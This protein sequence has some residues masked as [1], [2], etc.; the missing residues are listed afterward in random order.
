MALLFVLSFATISL[1]Q[2]PVIDY[3]QTPFAPNISDVLVQLQLA[4]GYRADRYIPRFDCSGSLHGIRCDNGT[5]YAV[6]RSL[7]LESAVQRPIATIPSEIGLLTTLKDLTIERVTYTTLPP[8]ILRLTQLTRLALLD[9]DFLAPIPHYLI[10]QPSVT[11]C[12]LRP[13]YNAIGRQ[14]TTCDV[15]SF[16][17]IVGLDP[18]CDRFCDEASLY[19]TDIVT[20]HNRDS[21]LG[22]HTGPKYPPV[23]TFFLAPGVTTAPV[24]TT[25]T[26]TTAEPTTL[27]ARD[28]TTAPENLTERAK[29]DASPDYRFLYIGGAIGMCIVYLAIVAAVPLV[30]AYRATEKLRAQSGAAPPPADFSVAPA[31][32]QSRVSQYDRVPP[33]HGANKEHYNSSFQDVL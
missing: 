10:Q 6:L 29:G 8:E 3:S 11:S 7:K 12:E 14:C 5:D 2:V 15:G 26:S 22:R 30:R 31:S 21:D 1:A 23:N 20:I 19:N 25:A 32:P 9:V 28:D 16:C 18:P 4:F 27:L 24:P 33:M 17:T 13:H